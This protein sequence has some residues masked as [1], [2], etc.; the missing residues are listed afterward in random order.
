LRCGCPYHKRSLPQPGI[1]LVRK[2]KRDLAERAPDHHVEDGAF[3]NGLGSASAARELHHRLVAVE[4]C[5]A[6]QLTPIA[7]AVEEED[8]PAPPV[9]ERH[10]NSA[11]LRNWS[12]ELHGS[13]HLDG[14]DPATVGTETEFA[15][16]LSDLADGGE[17]PALGAG[18]AVCL[19]NIGLWRLMV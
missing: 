8:V 6:W 9:G 19:E 12:G 1:L 14:V 11:L 15:I 4:E 7:I 18:L 16:D 10:E 2:I 13:G 5:E 17:S 3:L